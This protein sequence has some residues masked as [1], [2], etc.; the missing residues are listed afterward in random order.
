MNN[1][2][3]I[4]AIDQGTTSSRAIVFDKSSRIVESSQMEVGL[5]CPKSGWVEQNSNEI[6][7]TVFE[8]IKEVLESNTIDAKNI[9][10]IGITNQRETTIIWEKATGKPVYNAIVWQSRQ[11][12]E[13]C[14]EWERLGYGDIIHHKTGLII[15]PYFSASKVKWILENVS[16][17]KERA[18][19]GFGAPS[20]EKCSCMVA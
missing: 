6:W 19:N 5:V 15:N 1:K 2:D 8:T 12:Q 16:G 3:L 4:L 10:A 7:A 9:K 14:E 17:V 13:I 20:L 18:M 11:S